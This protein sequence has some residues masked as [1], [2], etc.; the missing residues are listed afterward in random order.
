MV[1]PLRLMREAHAPELR[2]GKELLE[3]L[4]GVVHRERR[5]QAAFAGMTAPPRDQLDHVIVGDLA[6]QL[7][8][9]EMSDQPAQL[10]PRILTAAV[11]LA[12]FG[13]IA[14]RHVL[15]L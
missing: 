9:T 13:P 2:A 6:D 10:S 4:G 12:D 8:F 1:T 3:L 14:S 15:Q 7:V 5:Q 11:V